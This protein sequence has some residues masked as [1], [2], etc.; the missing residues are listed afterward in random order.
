MSFL[1]EHQKPAPLIYTNFELM[2]MKNIIKYLGINLKYNMLT[3][4]QNKSNKVNEK[5]KSSRNQGIPFDTEFIEG[6]IVNRSAI[7]R[8][9]A[10]VTKRRSVKK[11]WQAGLVA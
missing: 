1:K 11:E 5:P 4:R 2:N 8:R 3:A 10:S 9:A 6:I 7:D